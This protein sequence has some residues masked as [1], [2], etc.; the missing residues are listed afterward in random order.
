MSDRDGLTERVTDLVL[1]C[2]DVQLKVALALRDDERVLV[3]VPVPVGVG[4][5]VAV[6]RTDCDMV[7]A[8]DCDMDPDFVTDGVGV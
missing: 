2:D 5:L 7:R 1:D 8:S 4:L 6:W 3:H